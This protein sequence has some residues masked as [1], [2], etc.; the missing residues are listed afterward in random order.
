LTESLPTIPGLNYAGYGG[1]AVGD[2][3]GDG[4]QDIV[5][6]TENY[7]SAFFV[8]G[9]T[10][11]G[12][13]IKQSVVM[14]DASFVRMLVRKVNGE[15]HLVALSGNGELREYAGW[16][17]AEIH[18]LSLNLPDQLPGV[19]I[20]DID[21]DGND[22]LVIVGTDVTNTMSVYDYASGQL[23]WSM[24]IEGGG[25]VLLA[26]LDADPA[27]EI[28]VGGY[29]LSVIDGATQATEWSFKG[30][31]GVCCLA[32][33][34]FNDGY[35]G[36]FVALA[37][38]ETISL[39]S[40]YPYALDWRLTNYAAFVL[41]SADLDHDGYDEILE[42]DSKWGGV[43]VLDPRTQTYGLSLANNTSY[44]LTTAGVDLEGNQ[45]PAVAFVSGS[46]ALAT[47][48]LM[49]IA[50]GHDGTVLW[51]MLNA[52][53]GPYAATALV[54]ANGDGHETLYYA[55]H[56][57]VYTMGSVSALDATTGELSWRSLPGGSLGS[58]FVFYPNSMLTIARSAAAPLVVVGGS[59]Y[60][61]HMVALDASDQHVVWQTPSDS[62]NPLFERSMVAMA[63][64]DPGDDIGPRIG[65]CV[66]LSIGNYSA[67]LAIFSSEDGSLEWESEGLATPPD[68]CVGI[69]AGSFVDGA[70]PLV[71]ALLTHSI[72]AFDATTHAQ[73]W[74]MPIGADG[75]TILKRGTSGPEFAVFRGTLLQFYDGATRTLLRQFELSAA[76]AAVREP[77]ND[78]R[79]LLVAAGDRLLIINGVTGSVLFTSDVLGQG[80]GA[81]NQLAVSDLGDG[82]YRVGAGSVIGVFRFVARMTDVL[83]GDGF[84]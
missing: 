10:G 19:A 16:P 40:A 3:D 75:A 21:N 32:A 67:G 26:Q 70:P 55:S 82:A 29:P 38:G 44:V 47:D 49:E 36:Q 71:V 31:Y 7:S 9:E 27:L 43:K 12:I 72:R 41:A 20:G 81:G 48:K 11:N 61:G 14:P 2:F 5:V 66:G 37:E 65:V 76:I 35:E 42:G 22:E 1:L 84:E 74:T 6:S 34:H 54:D 39:F 83:F 46:P 18:H 28:V 68:T 77:G 52:E 63:D 73:A 25:S 53:P 80:L 8:I 62:S 23:L 58:P 59:D 15:S 78:I 30:D 17:L 51:Q 50:D 60:D 13:G 69:A 24:P 64:F 33:G 79:R 4:K 57:S 56:G 45:Q